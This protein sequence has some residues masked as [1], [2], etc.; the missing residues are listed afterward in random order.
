[1]L[2]HEAEGLVIKDSG[3]SRRPDLQGCIHHITVDRVAHSYSEG[4]VGLASSLLGVKR[5]AGADLG[6]ECPA[7]KKLRQGNIGISIEP[8]DDRS[9]RK[10]GFVS[11]HTVGSKIVGIHEIRPAERPF[12]GREIKARHVVN[13]DELAGRGAL[14]ILVAGNQKAEAIA[15]PVLDQE[16]KSANLGIDGLGE[17]LRK[18]QT[19]EVGAKIVDR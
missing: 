3:Q 10:S 2:E 9:S 15:I 11:R 5:F 19:E 14:I 12:H 4:C 7:M 1:M 6:P 18:R 16:S 17:T 13:L 8:S